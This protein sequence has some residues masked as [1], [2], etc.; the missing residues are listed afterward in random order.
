MR[1]P[2]AR[3]SG[4]IASNANGSQDVSAETLMLTTL[5]LDPIEFC[6]FMTSNSEFP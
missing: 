4:P 6:A 5:G 1:S 3:E 2:R